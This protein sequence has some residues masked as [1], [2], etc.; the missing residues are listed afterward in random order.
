MCMNLF[1]CA[2]KTYFDKCLIFS[3]LNSLYEH[4]FEKSTLYEFISYCKCLDYLNVHIIMIIFIK[5]TCEK[6]KMSV[7][8]R[9]RKVGYI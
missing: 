4:K 1:A 9:Y 8:Y 7:C 6:I 3:P 5:S 2:E